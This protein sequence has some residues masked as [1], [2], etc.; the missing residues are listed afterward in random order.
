MYL[1]K[2]EKHL[3]PFLKKKRIEGKKIGFVPTMGALHRGH[4]S[5]IEKA[6]DEC[7]I[8]VCSIFVNPTQ[9]NNAKDLEKYPRTIEHDMEMLLKADCSVLYLPASQEI[10]PEGKP[11]LKNYDLG[12]YDKVLEAA[13]RPGHFQG[14]AN[15]VYRLMK[16]VNPAVLYLGQKD[17]QQIQ[18]I[19]KM[20][21]LENFQTK[22]EVCEIVRELSG[23]A[24]SSRN[25]RLNEEAW[26]NAA[27]ISQT[28]FFLKEKRN[29]FSSVKALREEGIKRLKKIPDSI[30]EYL[31]I[32]DAETLRPVEII[33]KGKLTII[34]TA[35]WINGVRL[36]DNILIENK[37]T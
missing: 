37:L 7:E 15:V 35:I 26:N 9:F 13:F 32:C 2:S 21:E 27:V 10:Y 36:I 23:L 33:V 19:R 30:V 16:K 14:V 5:L 25:V 28:L 17:F 1:F 3:A 4:I 22:I 8:V 12:Y 6:K 24:M 34:L 18:V 11:E 29:E 31:E 20:I